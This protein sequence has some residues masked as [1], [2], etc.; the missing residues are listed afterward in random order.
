MSGQGT[1]GGHGKGGSQSKSGSHGKVGQSTSGGHSKTVG[2]KTNANMTWQDRLDKSALLRS[3][4]LL[5]KERNEFRKAEQNL[6]QALAILKEPQD[7]FE[8]VTIVKVLH[9]LG[10]LSQEQG[11]FDKAEQYYLEALSLCERSLGPTAIAT[12]TRLNHLAWLYRLK[13]EMD[14]SENVLSKSMN[15]YLESLGAV[16]KPVA[17]LLMALAIMNKRNGNQEQADTY[18]QELNQ[19]G[20]LLYGSSRDVETALRISKVDSANK[21]KSTLDLQRFGIIPGDSND[22]PQVEFVIE[23]LLGGEKNQDD[24][25][26]N[27]IH[28]ECKSL[29]TQMDEYLVLSRGRLRGP[30]EKFQENPDGTITVQAGFGGNNSSLAAARLRVTRIFEREFQTKALTQAS[31]ALTEKG[32]VDGAAVPADL[33]EE[34]FRGARI[35]YSGLLLHEGEG[36]GLLVELIEALVNPKQEQK[37]A[38]RNVGWIAL[39]GWGRSQ[40]IAMQADTKAKLWQY[41]LI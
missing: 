28:K 1:S 16:N 32:F 36:S 27:S 9:E 40:G 13:G 34:F 20:E 12:A 2:S 18:R 7:D 17:L 38:F 10:S 31:D 14:K 5:C 11:Q 39:L 30:V 37:G 22:F 24:D 35:A 21:R 15:I 25:W 19:I 29:L 8:P 23:S 4:A 41:P 3:S 6:E 26:E 33:Q